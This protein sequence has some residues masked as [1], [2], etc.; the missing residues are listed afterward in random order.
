ME[1]MKTLKQGVLIAAFAT[2][3]TLS[4]SVSAIEG[5]QLTV[6]CPDVILGWPSLSGESY[7]VQW[8]PTLSPSTPWVTLTNSLPA[9]ETTNWTTFV[10]SNQVQCASD[11]ANSF[12]GSESELPPALSFA[13]SHVSEPMVKRADG[14]GSAVPLCIYP[15]SFDL[16]RFIILDPSTGDWVSGSQ[17]EISH[18]FLKRPQPEDPDPQD[19]PMP[20]DPGFYR[21]VANG[22]HFFGLTNGGVLSGVVDVPIEMSLTSTD[23][24]TGLAFY[25]GDSP[26]LRASDK[27]NG[28]P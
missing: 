5:L 4:A 7:I 18:P 16:S 28:S 13:Q 6:Q 23:Q 24:I 21:V 9:D 2:L 25:A 19:D 11:D 12:G 17:Y 1:P 10:H 3:V 26:L 20:P 8:R 22:L 15:P 27:N 14:S